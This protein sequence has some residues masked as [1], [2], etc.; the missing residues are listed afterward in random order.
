MLRTDTGTGRVHD[1][2]NSGT[3]SF[4]EF[5]ALH[6]FLTQAQQD[7]SRAD[8][9]RQGRIDKQAVRGLLEARGALLTSACLPPS[10]RHMH[11]PLQS[12]C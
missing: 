5:R 4:D 12:L 8:S 2:D 3:I 7:F 10:M 9:T 11:S 1:K 6:Q